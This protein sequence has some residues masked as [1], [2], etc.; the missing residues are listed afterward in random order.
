MKNLFLTGE[1][2]AGKS[3]VIR[4]TLALLPPIVCGGFRT[5]SVPVSQEA[6]IEVYL[7]K[8]WE[9]TPQDLSHLVGTRFGFG[10]FT[11]Y[12]KVFDS[13]GASIL[14][15]VPDGSALIIMDELGVMEND[16][17][18]FRKAV[19]EALSGKLP[20]LGVIKPKHTEFLDAV[21]AHE[22]S[23]IFEVTDRN[24]DELPQILAEKLRAILLKT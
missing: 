17:A 21:R 2:D 19:F 20:V 12:P 10:H 11:A 15:S 4:K 23:E 13:V 3:T 14:T 9:K 1:V 5:V 6:L 8:A 24:R 18:V 7:E 22:H 16:A